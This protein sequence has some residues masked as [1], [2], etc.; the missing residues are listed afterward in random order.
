MEEKRKTSF[1]HAMSVFVSF[2]RP[3]KIRFA[4]ITVSVIGAEILGSLF[5]PQILR[6]IV[7]LFAYAYSSAAGTKAIGLFGLLAFI[8]ISYWLL[9]RVAGFLQGGVQAGVSRDAMTDSLSHTL[10]HS[11]RFFQDQFTGSMM[12][13]I[14]RLSESIER[15]MEWFLWTIVPL[16]VSTIGI[17]VIVWR[18][19]WVLGV[20]MVVWMLIYVLSNYGIAIWKLKYDLDRSEKNTV[21]NGVMSDILSNTSTVKA[22][23]REGFEKKLF[24]KAAEEWREARMKT[25]LIGETNNAIQYIFI[26]FLEVGIVFYAIKRWEVGLLTVGTFAMYQLYIRS[27]TQNV[28]G[29]GRLI[30]SF[31]EAIADAKEMID[32]IEMPVEV[33]DLPEARPIAVKGAIIDFQ[34]VGFQY[35]GG[36]MILKSFSL[37]IASHEKIALVGSSGAG[38]STVT[39]L[40]FRFYD[41]TRGAIHIDG[42]NIAKVTQK[43]L[44]EAMSIVPQEPILFH[45]SLRDNIAYGKTNASEKDIIAAAKKAHCHE[46]ISKLPKGYDTFVGERGVKLSGGERQRVAIARAILKNA[47]ILVLDEA[48]SSLD[49]ESESLIQDALRELMKEKTVIVIAHRLSTIMQMDRIIVM[50]KGK[51]VDQGTHDQLLKKVGIYKKLWNIQ[52]GGFK[53]V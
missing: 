16:F 52:A 32:V 42:K 3:Y 44:R 45:R 12:R 50:E 23:A 26:I 21:Q 17:G 10:K 31:F 47:P 2:L 38:K 20:G 7:D 1:W 48:T 40:L 6:Q 41:V 53:D 8:T 24:F 25:W 33:P 29:M 9:Y 13:R 36:S 30:R 5:V 15:I 18:E 19:S 46:F 49:S 4:I 35:G 34:D 11:Y 27:I 51:V 22:F 14:Q 43:S 39:K 37:S 28:Y